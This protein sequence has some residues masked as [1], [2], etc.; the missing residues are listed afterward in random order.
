[1]ISFD[2]IIFSAGNRLGGI[3][4]YFRELLQAA[5]VTE[6][7]QAIVHDSKIK[8]K[9]LCIR[10]E[11]L[12]YRP[13]RFLE[14][15]RALNDLPEGVLHSSYYRV[16]MQPRVRNIVTVYDF[17]YEKFSHGIAA[18][19]HSRQKRAAILNADAVICIS[20]NTR[21]DLLQILPNY[22][23][24]QVFVTHLA[25]SAHFRPLHTVPT[26]LTGKPFALFV[27][28]RSHYKNFGM[29]VR[30]LKY[31]PDTAL[32]C[33]GG[34]NFSPE[35]KSMLE[36]TLPDRFVHAGPVSGE[37]LNEFYNGAVCLLYPSLYEGFGIP[38]L[39]AMQAGCPFVA[40]NK[41]SIPEVAGDAGILIDGSE[42]QLLSD[43][44]REC[45][46]RR[47]ELRARG[48][49]QAAKFSWQ[50]TFLE[51]QAIYRQQLESL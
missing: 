14:R 41:S 8:P 10:P 45:I 42:P 39:E 34:G 20:H 15:F 30:A 19:V 43:A 7:M 12:A 6:E 51:T 11:Q 1:M 33:V 26:T 44:I 28:S 16:S 46:A 4:V 49:A 5:A 27:G 24:E 35:E 48:L 3:S 29:A 38:P 23:E 40:I 17:T 21:R 25:A 18:L 37:Q 36:Q 13:A 22:P 31:L 32:V 50:K 2:G 47:S 9:E